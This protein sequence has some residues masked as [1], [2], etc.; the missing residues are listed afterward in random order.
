MVVVIVLVLGWGGGRG[1]N[2]AKI[3]FDGEILVKLNFTYQRS[4]KNVEHVLSDI[5]IWCI[6]GLLF[7]LF[8]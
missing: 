2:W 7:A 5:N 1:E 8:L 4:Q 6:I 3:K